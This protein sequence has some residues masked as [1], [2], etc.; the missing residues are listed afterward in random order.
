MAGAWTPGPWVKD[1]IV[2]SYM[3]PPYG[4][5]L[6][7]CLMG[8][9]VQNAGDTATMFQNHEANSSIILAAPH[10]AEALKNLIDRYVEVVT[11]PDCSCSPDDYEVQKAHAALAKARGEA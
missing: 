10:M 7:I 11:T 8:E 3:S 9:P 2:I 4:Y 5:P 1:G 6:D